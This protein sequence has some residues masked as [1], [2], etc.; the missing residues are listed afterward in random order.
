MQIL[1]DFMKINKNSAIYVGIVTFFSCNIEKWSRK[2]NFI[3]I[4]QTTS[5]FFLKQ[6]GCVCHCLFFFVECFIKS[7][8]LNLVP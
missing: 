1:S 4:L 3:A 7:N 8:S 2:E 6:F 5:R